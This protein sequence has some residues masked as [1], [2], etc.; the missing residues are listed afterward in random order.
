MFKFTNEYGGTAFDHGHIEGITVM[1]KTGT[2]EVKKHH[3]SDDSERDLENWHP[4]ASHAWFA[5]YAPA[6]DPQ[7]VIIVLVEHGGSGGRVAW[8]IAKQIIEGFFKPEAK[9]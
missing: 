6:D 7:M 1:G 9:K 3:R 2:A 4:N 8:P 5:G